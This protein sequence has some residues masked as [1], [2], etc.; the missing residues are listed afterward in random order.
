M[1]T[2]LVDSTSKAKQPD[3][4]CCP[5]PRAGARGARPPRVRTFRTAPRARRRLVCAPPTQNS[6]PPRPSLSS[7]AA[8][9]PRALAEARAPQGG[10]T[11]IEIGAAWAASASLAARRSP[12]AAS[13][14]QARRRTRPSAPAR[15]RTA[16]AASRPGTPGLNPGTRRTRAA[17]QARAL[18]GAR[19]EAWTLMDRTPAPP[20]PSWRE[21]PPR[22]ADRASSFPVAANTS[23]AAAWTP[24]TRTARAT[25]RTGRRMTAQARGATRG[26][27]RSW[28]ARSAPRR[29]RTSRSRFAR[30]RCRT[31]RT[32]PGRCRRKGKAPR[33]RAVA[34]RTRRTRSG[35]TRSQQGDG[36]AP[37]PARARSCTPRAPAAPGTRSARRCSTR[38]F[39]R[40]R[41]RCGPSAWSP[42]RRR[43][44]PCRG[45][46]TRRPCVLATRASPRTKPRAETNPRWWFARWRASA[47]PPFQARSAARKALLCLGAARR[48]SGP[49][50]R[51][52]PRRTRCTGSRRARPRRRRGARPGRPRGSP[53][54][55]RVRRC[56]GSRGFR[57]TSRGTAMRPTRRGHP[58]PPPWRRACTVFARSR[59]CARRASLPTA[60]RRPR[61]RAPARPRACPRRRTHQQRHG[62]RPPRERVAPA[63]RR[64]PLF[65]RAP[66]LPPPPP[67][68]E[69][70]QPAALRPLRAPRRWAR[71]GGAR[72]ARTAAWARRR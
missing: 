36:T 18:K 40:P 17:S 11:Q 16:R 57:A 65:R 61:T 49:Q 52:R 70:Q 62:S 64:R 35:P 58:K 55:R 38:A 3:A 14:E 24:R 32:P 39:P 41:A 51:P 63:H 10:G 12:P 37:A 33:V 68:R 30:R 28:K 44:G 67:R 34:R 31:R 72:T 59:R 15:R 71:E 48:A 21:A 69:T 60:R 46:T 7:L 26:C 4:C 20:R 1:K 27:R 22:W 25:P 19:G 2:R 9:G 5:P 56:T 54:P 29:A 50:Q 23:L 66:T 8:S 53:T 43:R 6:C 13:A 47:P 42:L 45:R